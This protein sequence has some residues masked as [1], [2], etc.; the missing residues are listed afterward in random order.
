MTLLGKL[1]TRNDDWD[2]RIQAMENISNKLGVDEEYDDL[3]KPENL[4]D[5]LMDWMVQ[6]LD[7]R[8]NVQKNCIRFITKYI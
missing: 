8:Q 5:L 3:L 4:G 6:S 2:F 7:E 1:S